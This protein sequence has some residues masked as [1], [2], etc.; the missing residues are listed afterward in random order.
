MMTRRRRVLAA[1]AAIVSAGLLALAGWMYAD[2]GVGMGLREH[3]REV[4]ARHDEADGGVSDADVFM[5]AMGV[6]SATTTRTSTRL[7]V[8]FIG[9]RGPGS[10]PCGR[11]Y[12]AEAIESANAV[13]VI[14]AGRPRDLLER[15]NISLDT[16]LCTAIG[17]ERTATVTL[18]RPLGER[19][20]LDAQTGRPVRVTTKP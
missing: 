3:A 12:D 13:V 1:A 17:Y 8:T 14:V 20:V 2:R 16:E 11:D 4:L 18:T 10:E 15:F 19:A 9:A 6:E 7:T 5:A